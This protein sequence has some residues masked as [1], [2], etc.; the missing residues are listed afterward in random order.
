M[1]SRAK[2]GSR[3]RMSQLSLNGTSPA[4]VTRLG[5]H[6]VPRLGFLVHS[7][8]ILEQKDPHRRGFWWLVDELYTLISPEPLELYRKSREIDE[9]EPKQRAVTYLLFVAVAQA[10]AM[11]K[12]IAKST[13]MI[14]PIISPLPFMVLMTPLPTPTIA[15]VGP[16]MLS[17]QPGTGS[18]S[19][20]KTMEGR[21]MA[22][23][24]CPFSLSKSCSARAL[25]N[26]Y[27][28]G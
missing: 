20:A 14:S 16:F 13:G 28:L 26:V 21:T 9:D 27:V 6:I 18:F 17:I 19:A 10:T 2:A 15:A 25:V 23:G 24:I 4:K 1:V 3:W 12:L 22:S 8:V 7:S 5:Y 11:V